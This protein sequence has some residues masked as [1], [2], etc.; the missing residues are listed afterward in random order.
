MKKA[1]LYL[2][3]GQVLEGHSFG[4][5]GTAMGELV[6]TTGMTG[7]VESL[8]DPSYYG[9]LVVYT[10]PQFGN[11]GICHKDKESPH[12]Q[13]GGVVVREYCQTPSN[14]RCEETVDAFLKAQNVVGI[15]GVDTRMLTQLL[16]DG[17]VLNAVITTEEGQPDWEALKAYRVTQSV[18]N[19]SEKE[20]TVRMPQ[21]EAA[22]VALLDYGA[23]ESIA[24][25]LLARGCKVTIYPYNTP[26]E[27]ILSAGHHGVMLSNGP[28]DPADNPFC[29]QQIQKL[30]G[31]LPMFGICLGHQ[32]MAL[33]AGAKT[34]KLKFGHR[35]A[36]QPAMDLETGEVSITSQNHGYAVDSDTVKLGK[37]RFANANDGTCEGR[38]S[39]AEG[40]YLQFH[41]GCTGPKDSFLFDRFVDDEGGFVMPLDTY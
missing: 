36:N 27:E 4:A 15:A 33:A 18:E 11:Y 22:S 9:Q 7:C 8:T 13:M 19:T 25:S 6:F 14:F 1:Y 21:G 30:F 29:I 41:P 5:A 3:N 24:N 17:G 37:V 39:G 28:G 26:A 10:F 35:G 38:L 23:K 20:V 34:K 16:R 2:E 32:M 12:C 40:V 31:K